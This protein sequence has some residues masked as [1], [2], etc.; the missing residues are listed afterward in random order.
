MHV[1]LKGSCVICLMLIFFTRVAAQ[2]YSIS[3][4]GAVPDTSLLSTDAIQT[5]INTCNKNGGGEVIIPPGNFKTGSIKLLSNV[6]LVLENGSILYGS[7]NLKDYKK[8]KTSFTSL[9]TQDSILQ[10]IYAD[11]AT[12]TGIRGYG[13]INGQGSAFT[14]QPGDEGIKRPFLL[15]FI[16]CKDVRVENVSLKSSPCWMQHYLA[17]QRVTLRGLRIF[18]RANLNN[19]AIDIDGCKDVTISDIIS[20][21]EDDGITLKS[22]SGWITENVTITNCIV[23]SRWNAIKMGTESNGGFKNIAISNCVIKS[24]SIMPW[25][26]GITSTPLTGIALMITDGGILHNITISNIIING[27]KA[28]LYIRLANRAR[29]FLEGMPLVNVGEVAG[30]SISNVHITNAGKN[31]CSFTGLPEHP[32]KHIRL[33]NIY[34]QSAG[35]G[36]DEDAARKVPEDP[37]GY[38]QANIWNPMPAFGFFVRHVT[39]V[40]FDNVELNTETSDARPAFYFDDAEMVTVKNSIIANTN[41]NVPVLKLTS[42]RNSSFT[43]NIFR[44]KAKCLVQAEGAMNKEVFIL[45]NYYRGVAEKIICSDTP[46]G[47][48]GLIY[49]NNTQ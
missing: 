31:G 39:N 6:T 30:I 12:N 21:T 13:E 28:P 8:V 38:P 40:S 42:T 45:N 7:K 35:G 9:R 5:A 3:E 48:A 26:D 4:F 18:N 29:P 33:S 22:T 15:R 44:G 1:R 23:S 37:K 14:S 10:L 47:A 17:C 27:C 24:T 32:L 20:D 46:G 16:L 25:H 41:K 34:M 43:G 49:K 36:S 11:K 2:K 19:D